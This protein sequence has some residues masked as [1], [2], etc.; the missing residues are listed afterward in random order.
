MATIEV[1]EET[2]RTVSFAARMAHLTEGA[3]IRRLI[4]TSTWTEEEAPRATAQG[5]A[6]YADYDGHRVRARYFEPAR[7]E[8]VDG[9]LAGQSF[10]SPTGAAR[11][12]IRNFNPDINDNRN[13]WAFWQIED[14]TGGRRSLQSIRPGALRSGR[15][16]L[17][18]Q[19]AA[20]DD[21][22][23]DETNDGIARDFGLAP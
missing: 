3:V 4:A 13:G 9:P 11:A 6:I 15:G 20:S 14:E 23:S 10:K 1:D 12:V 17:R 2:K 19:L 21:W 5:V 8:I 18:G 7:V 22:D 16:S